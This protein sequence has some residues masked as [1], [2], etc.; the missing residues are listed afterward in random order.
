MHD[1]SMMRVV[2]AAAEGPDGPPVLDPAVL[3]ALPA[4]GDE[5]AG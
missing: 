3:G 5:E 1:A 4:W 2:V